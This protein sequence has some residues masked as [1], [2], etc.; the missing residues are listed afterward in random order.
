MIHNI[1]FFFIR[2]GHRAECFVP[3]YLC[4]EELKMDVLSALA[5]ALSLAADAMAVSVCCGSRASAGPCGMQHAE[6]CRKKAG[7]RDAPGHAV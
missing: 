5:A 4:E 1:E 6:E 3:C 2:I 7:E